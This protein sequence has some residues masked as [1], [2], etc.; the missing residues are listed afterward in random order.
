[1][2]RPRA[3]RR[4]NIIRAASHAIY[5]ASATGADTA[6]IGTPFFIWLLAGMQRTWS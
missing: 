1:M 4:A 3:L 2:N 6:V 5:P